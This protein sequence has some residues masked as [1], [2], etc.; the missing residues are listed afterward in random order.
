MFSNAVNMAMKL[1]WNGY[2]GWTISVRM[3]EHLE[4]T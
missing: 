2:K 1:I 4:A 3:G